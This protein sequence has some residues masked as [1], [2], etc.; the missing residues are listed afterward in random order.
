MAPLGHYVL[1]DI[2]SRQGR[3]AGQLRSEAERAARSSRPAREEDRLAADELKVCNYPIANSASSG[4]PE[5]SVRSPV[6]CLGVGQFAALAE[7]TWIR[8]P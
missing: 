1:A 3:A 6:S 4:K 2:Y 7:L 5:L 8:L